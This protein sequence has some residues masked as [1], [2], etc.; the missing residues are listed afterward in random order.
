MQLRY[1]QQV[2]LRYVMVCMVL[3]IL[4]CNDNFQFGSDSMIYEGISTGKWTRIKSYG[5][6]FVEN[7][8]QAVSWDILT[9]AMKRLRYC[10]I[11]D[12]VHDE[13]VIECSSSGSWIPSVN[14]WAKLHRGLRIVVFYQ[15]Q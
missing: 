12:H 1:C 3:Q 2:Y 4:L 13:L 8:V 11:A 9:Y 6:K 14:I 10:Q 7:L 15:K 5:S